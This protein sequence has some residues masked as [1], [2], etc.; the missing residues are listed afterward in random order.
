M[1]TN[2]DECVTAKSPSSNILI[3][4]IYC[5]WSGGCA[6]GSLGAGT[7]ISSVTYSKVYSV[8]CNQMRM[9]KSNGG[10]GSVQNVTFD[11]FIGHNNAYSLDIDQAWGSM[12][13]VSG[14]GIHLKDITFSNWKGDCANGVQRGPIQFKCAA[15]APCTGMTV[16]DFSVWTNAG[17]LSPERAS[18][19]GLRE[20][21]DRVV[22]VLGTS[23]LSRSHILP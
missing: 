5:N 23:K 14:S 8:N 20:T 7:A 4:Q 3:E 12:T 18:R 21:E 17:S 10:S 6:I 15:G 11:K 2:K 1:V 22:G 16:K 9:I 13:P 19:P